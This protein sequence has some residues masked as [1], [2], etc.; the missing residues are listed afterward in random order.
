M[1]LHPN[2]SALGG[3]VVGPRFW[4][5][6]SDDK[7][8]WN[9]SL[10]WLQAHARWGCE[11][12]DTDIYIKT[13]EKKVSWIS[14]SLAASLCPPVKN[15]LDTALLQRC[16]A[17]ILSFCLEAMQREWDPC[18]MIRK[19]GASREEQW[20]EWSVDVLRGHS[21]CCLREGFRE[22]LGRRLQYR[23][24]QEKKRWKKKRGRAKRKAVIVII[25][26]LIPTSLCG[27]SMV[28]GG[29]VGGWQVDFRFKFPN[30]FFDQV[31]I[32]FVASRHKI[33]FQLTDKQ[34]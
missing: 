27:W 32:R 13:T 34:A 14:H 6:T 33:S 28:V 18:K 16:S 22:I 25:L 8:A 12:F 2:S 31:Q 19:R 11:E 23:R 21:Q 4:M 17:Q 29:G 3:N 20:E 10:F 7:K 26:F 30:F 9:L 15:K 5:K 24:D 1:P